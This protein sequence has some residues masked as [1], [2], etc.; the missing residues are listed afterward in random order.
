MNRG[1]GIHEN[2][3]Y[4]EQGAAS[5]NPNPTTPSPTTPGSCS[6]TQIDGA[7]L[8]IGSGL[9]KMFVV[10]TNR[11]IYE[12]RNNN[13]V[14]LPD[15]GF[16]ANRVDVGGGGQA[17]VVATDG[18][19][20][21]F[22]PNNRWRMLDGSASDVGANGNEL[23]VVGRGGIVYKRNSNLFNWTRINPSVRAKKL[24]V[25]VDGNAWIVGTD[26]FVYQL[27]NN[28][29]LRKGNFK[30]RDIGIAE[31]SDK[32]WALSESDGS[33]HFYEGNQRWSKQSDQ[34]GNHISVSDDNRIW[35]VSGNR[36]IRVSACEG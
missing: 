10:G 29:W 4:F 7:A 26:G 36:S 28:R 21:R 12:R 20:Y 18:K 34:T 24:D 16:Q 9:G 2:Y 14:L 22:S 25:Y 3:V 5:T 31:G 23:Y 30:A 11:R 13:W 6:F 1:Q 32:I 35:V 8:D 27:S 33:L 17:M 19:I 15:G